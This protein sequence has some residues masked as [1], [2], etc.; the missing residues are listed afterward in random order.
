[1]PSGDQGKT[2]QIQMKKK[3]Q[4]QKRHPSLKGPLGV[5]QVP[6]ITQTASCLGC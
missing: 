5:Q 6:M 1:M 2:L 3:G 4:S